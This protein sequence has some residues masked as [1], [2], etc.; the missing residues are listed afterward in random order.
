MGNCL[1][2]RLLEVVTGLLSLRRVAKLCSSTVNSTTIFM[3]V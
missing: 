3:G 1:F 2:V